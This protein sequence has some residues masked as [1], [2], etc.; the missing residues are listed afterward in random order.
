MAANGYASASPAEK[1]AKA[2]SCCDFLVLSGEWG[3]VSL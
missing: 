3:S 1:V 2:R